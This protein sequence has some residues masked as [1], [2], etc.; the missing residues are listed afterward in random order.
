[1][2]LVLKFYHIREQQLFLKRNEDGVNGFVRRKCFHIPS[3][4]FL[5][6]VTPTLI[7]GSDFSAL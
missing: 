5:A 6:W 7:V 2:V 1:M 3:G 4:L